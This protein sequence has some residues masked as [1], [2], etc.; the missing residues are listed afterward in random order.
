[1]ARNQLTQKDVG[2][3]PIMDL[4]AHLDHMLEEIEDIPL[5]M[6][7][8]KEMLQIQRIM[9]QCDGLYAYF[10]AMAIK[11]KMIKKVYKSS[12]EEKYKAADAMDREDV[13]RSYAE[14]VK[15]RYNAASRMVTVK[16][17]FIE[18]LKMQGD[19]DGN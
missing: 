9:S 7:T 13:F 2:N 17:Q 12:A 4:I 15:F 5:S 1:M 8:K 11:F 6:E 16:Q 19:Y 10:N 18:E 14:T 3:L